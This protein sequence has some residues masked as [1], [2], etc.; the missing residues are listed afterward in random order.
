MR[1]TD[2]V[3]STGPVAFPVKMLS[4]SGGYCTAGTACSP[5]S[6]P[7]SSASSVSRHTGRRSS[8]SVAHSSR[9]DYRPCPSPARTEQ[10]RILRHLDGAGRWFGVAG[11]VVLRTSHMPLLFGTPAG[12]CH[13]SAVRVDGI[14]QGGLAA[15]NAEGLC[16][17]AHFHIIVIDPLI[18]HTITVC[19][20]FSVPPKCQ[21]LPCRPTYT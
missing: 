2:L 12:Y 18:S 7:R 17:T 9:R 3:V 16:Q 21:T 5:A 13:R 19:R 4:E 6:R 15:G 8:R 11:A 20:C 14:H 10:S 1:L